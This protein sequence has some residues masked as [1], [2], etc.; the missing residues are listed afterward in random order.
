MR[1][2]CV[3][4][5]L[6]FS[7]A[8]SE[9]NHRLCKGYK[10]N[11]VIKESIYAMW[12]VVNAGK[13]SVF[14]LSEVSPYIKQFLI[15]RVSAPRDLQD[16]DPRVVVPNPPVC[17]CCRSL[18]IQPTMTLASQGGVRRGSSQSEII[19]WQ[20]R[21]WARSRICRYLHSRISLSQQ[22]PRH[23][24]RAGWTLP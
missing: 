10:E 13:S 1:R 9:T 16:Q 22:I 24:I 11:E 2:T 3:Q 7:L 8:V 12:E 4:L 17:D 5:L 15:N 21:R 19:L 18:A 6:W 20:L 23:R 14:C